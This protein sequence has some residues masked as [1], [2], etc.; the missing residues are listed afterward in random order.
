MTSS[1]SPMVAAFFFY[2]FSGVGKESF[3]SFLTSSP[4]FLILASIHFEMPVAASTVAQTHFSRIAVPFSAF[5]DTN[6][7]I[8]YT[9]SHP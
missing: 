4:P 7:R 5:S 3:A 6:F 1:E 9:I 2:D 8:L